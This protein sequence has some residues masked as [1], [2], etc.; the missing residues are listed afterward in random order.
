M[1]HVKIYFKKIEHN[2]SSY[3]FWTWEVKVRRFLIYFTKDWGSN[4]DAHCAATDAIN[5]AS[6]YIK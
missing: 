1:K 5:A 4:V 2:D 3:D 6:W